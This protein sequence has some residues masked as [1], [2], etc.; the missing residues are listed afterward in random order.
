MTGRFGST[1]DGDPTRI[2]LAVSQVKQRT[3]ENGDAHT[4]MYVQYLHVCTECRAESYM[5]L[6]ICPLSSTCVILRSSNLKHVPIDWIGFN[7]KVEPNRY[8]G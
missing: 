1:L 8:L 2:S 3:R 5:V 4:H 6:Y 7:F